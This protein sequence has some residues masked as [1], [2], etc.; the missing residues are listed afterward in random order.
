[1]HF[2][3]TSPKKL[4]KRGFSHHLI[5]PLLAILAVG[6]IGAYLTFASKADSICATEMTG[7]YSTDSGKYVCLFLGNRTW[8]S[9]KAYTSCKTGEYAVYGSSGYVCKSAPRPDATKCI[10]NQEL[11]WGNFSS[12]LGRGHAS[13][14]AIDIKYDLLSWGC[15]GQLSSSKKTTLRFRNIH[16][17][18]F[19]C[20]VPR[21]ALKVGMEHS[22]VSYLKYSL[23]HA[24]IGLAVPVNTTFDIG[25]K[26]A[27]MD[28][29]RKYGLVVSSEVATDTWIKID[30]LATN[31]EKQ[32]GQSYANIYAAKYGCSQPYPNL[33]VGSVD[34]CTA[35]LQRSLNTAGVRVSITKTFDDATKS[36]LVVFQG[37]KSLNQSGVADPATWLAIDALPANQRQL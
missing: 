6:A 13:P 10:S 3:N 8:T 30:S 31:R 26:N 37:K 9:N 18:E 1:M 21:L 24:A 2:F 33:Q 25:T 11:V 28:F 32:P 14:N 5:L 7:P 20:S 16:D 4:T 17:R 22:C 15:V 12:Y 19:G 36:A 35:Y 34:A 23:N 29:Q 27:V